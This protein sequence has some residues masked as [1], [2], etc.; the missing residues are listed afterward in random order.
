MQIASDVL[1]ALGHARTDENRLF[2]SAQLDRALY[3]KTNKVL[4]AAGG[5]W[6]RKEKAHVFPSD[7]GER[8]DQLLMTG[9]IVIPQ[10]EFNYFP[11]P[12]D[13]IAAMI[14]GAAPTA[15][16]RILE[17]GF[18]DGRII[19]VVQAVSP[20]A[21]IT[22]VELMDDRFAQASADKALSSTATL[23]HADFLRWEP[24]QKF[25]VILMNPPFFKRSDVKHVNHAL[26]MLETGG[27]FASVMPASIEFR[28]DTLTVELRKRIADLGGSI[29]K[30]PADTFK[31]VGT[32]VN[33]VMVKI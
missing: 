7:A 16:D 13:I 9:E 5:K 25:N 6:N 2:L 20:G 24:E 30:L 8:L 4:D 15:G 33:T 29:E 12:P 10:D 18:G 3:L 32:R 17:P 21:L 31:S 22:G 26:D 28:Q 19:R 11:T 1:I 27:R 23:I 14:A